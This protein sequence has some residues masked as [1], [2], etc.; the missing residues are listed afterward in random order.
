MPQDQW[1]DTLADAAETN[2]KNPPW[3][4]D[5]YG[6]IAHDAP[7]CLRSGGPPSDVRLKGGSVSIGSTHR[8]RPHQKVDSLSAELRSSPME[9][10][11]KPA[12]CP[13]PNSDE[14]RR[15]ATADVK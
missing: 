8:Q 13:P 14:L 1:Q 10:E 15:S 4:I 11:Q 2:E 3:E 5:V 7:G 12:I 6:V 9:T